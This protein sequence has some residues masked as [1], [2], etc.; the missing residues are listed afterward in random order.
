MLLLAADVEPGV[1]QLLGLRYEDASAQAGTAYEYRLIALTGSSERPV[2]SVTV[3]AGGYRPA[4]APESLTAVAGRAGA[5]LRWRPEPR[6]SAYHV[7]RGSRRDG[8]DA[9]RINDAPVVVFIRDQGVALEAATTFFRDSIGTRRDTLRYWVEGIDAFG[10]PSQRS[11]AAAFVAPAALTLAAPGPVRASVAGDTVAVSW[12]PSPDS[13]V[14]AYQ[15][16]RADA[17]TGPFVK[18]GAPVRGLAQADPGRPARRLIWYR[19]TAV[20]RAGHESDPSPVALAEVRDLTPPAAPE[21]LVARADT[22]RFSLRWRRVDAADLRG[23]RV[24]RASTAD[25][26]FG[27]LSATPRR[28]PVFTDT[29]RRRADHPFYYRVTAVDSAFNESPPSAVLAVRPPDV[30]PPSA[31][32]IASVRPLDRA[33]AIVRLPNPEPDVVR[34][35]LRYRA[36]GETAWREADAT[37]TLRGLVAGRRH[38]VTLI[39]IDDAGNRSQPSPVVVGTPADRQAPDRPDVRRAQF[40]PRERGVVVEWRSNGA[41]RVLVLRREQHQAFRPVGESAG[42]VTRFVDRGVRAG[43]Q[44]EYVVRARDGF[45]NESESRARRVEVPVAG[46]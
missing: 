13:N 43:R 20:D 5:A 37:D 31:P 2:A 39:A 44:Y 17:D 12:Q 40:E 22:G 27:M 7:Y 23:Y 8:A 4:A 21:S 35:R 33:L 46:S 10:R 30:T 38:E 28:D 18:L 1:A 41:T 25:G 24:Y 45:G 36:A 6:F 19:V 14:A 42:G 3:I 26:T 16:W 32:R 29:I 11:A 9:R 15:V 34:Y